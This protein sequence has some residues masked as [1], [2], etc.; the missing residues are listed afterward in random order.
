M[1]WMVRAVGG[2]SLI[3]ICTCDE[4]TLAVCGSRGQVCGHPSRQGTSVTRLTRSEV[5]PSSLSRGEE[6]HVSEFEV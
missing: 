4:S 6:I 5:S 3:L 1:V 2:H